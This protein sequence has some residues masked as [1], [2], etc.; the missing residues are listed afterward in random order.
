VFIVLWFLVSPMASFLP[1][2]AEVIRYID[3]RTHFNSMVRGVI[4]LKGIIFPIS[5]MVFFLTLGT[6]SLES[7]R[8][9]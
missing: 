7:R 4:E 1:G 3:I 5:L 6:V 9:R 2:L 8:W